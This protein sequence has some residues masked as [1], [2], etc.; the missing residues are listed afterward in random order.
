M[1]RETKEFTTKGG[2]VI[3][4]YPKIKGREFLDIAA[5]DRTGND[6]AQGIAKAQDMMAK[7]IVSV[8]GVKEN[9]VELVKDLDLEDYLEITKVVA[10]LAGN[11]QTEK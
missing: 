3:V 9:C 4:Y 6:V 1:E 10:S 11:F 8:D 5:K 7:V 2:H